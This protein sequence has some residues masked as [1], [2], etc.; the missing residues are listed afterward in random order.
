MTTIKAVRSIEDR[1]VCDVRRRAGEAGATHAMETEV[2][3]P[4]W[5]AVAAA[6]SFSDV[7]D[8]VTLHR[9]LGKELGRVL[10]DA[11]D[12]YV[13]DRGAG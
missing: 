3:S 9:V 8:L 5:N 10:Q 13:A 11:V 6:K 7:D 4:W 2:G 1:L 12:G